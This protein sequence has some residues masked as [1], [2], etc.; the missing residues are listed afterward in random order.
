[1]D[2]ELHVVDMSPA[3]YAGHYN[4]RSMIPADVI[5]TA[6][7]WRERYIPTGG[8]CMLFN[9]LGQYL[10]NGTFAFVADR[11]PSIKQS[12]WAGYKSSRTHPGPIQIS[13]GVAEYILQDCGFNIYYRDG[14]EADDVVANIVRA[15]HERYERIFVHTGDSDLY[16]LV[17]DKVTVL[18]SSSKAK[19]VTRENYEYTVNSKRNVAYNTKVFDKFL[20]G[21]PGKDI[22]SLSPY[23]Q[24]FL[25]DRVLCTEAMRIKAGDWVFMRS[26]FERCY[27]Q[28]YDR[29]QLF[30]PLPIDE[31]WEI[32]N[33]ENLQRIKEWAFEIG[34]RKIMA[35]KG[36]VSKQVQELLDL[37]LYL[38]E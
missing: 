30:Y 32:S 4:R 24:K 31:P 21:D 34:C 15:N 29:L 38:D 28:L 6:E 17:D 13:K 7:G 8:T 33:Q 22:P 35:Q 2:A 20:H 9:M 25:R 36:D 19:T 11:Q 3:I 5:Q 18:P 26:Y 37:G 12:M 14:Y 1:M 27:P 23:D 10:A 16:I